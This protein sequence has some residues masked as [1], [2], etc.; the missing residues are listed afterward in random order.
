MTKTNIK[1]KNISEVTIEDR[2]NA[3]E[4]MVNAY[5]HKNEDGEIEYTP[6]FRKVGQIIAIVKYFIEGV[7]FDENE[8]IYNSAVNDNDVKLAVNKVLSCSEFN[9]LIDDVKDIVEYKKSENIA[10]LQNETISVLAYKLNTL[11][12]SE[13][14]KTKSE[15]EAYENF[16]QWIDE[17]RKLNSL[18][19][20]EMQKEFAEKL[21]AESFVDT[22]IK[23]YSESEIHNK[24]KEIIESSKKIR[25]QDKKI[26]EL[27][28]ELDKNN[29]KH[30][31]RNVLSDK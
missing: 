18:I 17:Q 10:K 19:T 31:V 21:D 25:E 5:F 11:I 6:Y 26:I 13:T 15:L 30:S 23:K 14:E 7:E 2:A 22:V 29:Q 1:V 24:N 3:I 4:I 27:K 9:S 28:K 12:D 8:S 20:P 16:I